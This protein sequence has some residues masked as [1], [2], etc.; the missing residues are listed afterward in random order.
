MRASGAERAGG[1]DREK[2]RSLV[3]RFQMPSKLAREVAAGTR[4]LSDVLLEMQRA[5]SARLLLSAHQICPQ[6]AVQVR[7]GLLTPD[8]A[9]RQARLRALKRAPGYLASR[10]SRFEGR[11]VLVAAVGGRLLQGRFVRT[12]VFEVSLDTPEAPVPLSTH[13]L[14]LVAAGE[15]RRRLL[16]RGVEWGPVEA[17]LAPGALAEIQA[18]RDVKAR[19]L[20]AAQESGGTITWTTIEGDRIRGRITDFGRYEVVLLTSQ[21]P[22][23]VLLRHAFGELAS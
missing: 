10:L 5:E 13:D 15:D 8:E 16:K 9:R 12:S 1:K 7:Q 17:R 19:R 11:E 4:S 2:I 18:R 14:K 20:L 3:E 6:E 22:E 23:I 21:G